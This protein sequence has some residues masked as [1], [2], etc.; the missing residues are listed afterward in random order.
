MIADFAAP[1]YLPWN[2]ASCIRSVARYFVTPISDSTHIPS[3]AFANRGEADA[4]W[5]TTPYPVV[6][7]VQYADAQTVTAYSLGGNEGDAVRMPTAWRFE[8]SKDTLEW[9]P[10]DA[11]SDIADWPG[12]GQMTFPIAKPGAYRA[13]R[14]VFT[15]GQSDTMRIYKI[16]LETAKEPSQNAKDA[17]ADSKAAP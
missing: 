7:S 13:Y 2:S 8:A 10:L 3:G 15:R 14:F 6:L 16:S 9:V 4:F 12:N 17:K 5:E 1:M 11:Q